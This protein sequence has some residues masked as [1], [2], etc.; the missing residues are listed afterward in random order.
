LKTYK[1]KKE[2][3]FHCIL[4]SGEKVFVEETW[5]DLEVDVVQRRKLGLLV[6]HLAKVRVERHELDALQSDSINNRKK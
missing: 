5:L 6:E 2:S 1:E 3:F 4:F